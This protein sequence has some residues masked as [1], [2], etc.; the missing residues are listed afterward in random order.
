MLGIVNLAG[1]SRLQEAEFA[2][3]FPI[4]EENSQLL[5]QLEV[6]DLL[7]L[8]LA[9]SSLIF[10]GLASLIGSALDVDGLSASRSWPRSQKPMGALRQ[11]QQGLCPIFN[12][13]DIRRSSDGAL[14]RSIHSSSIPTLLR[15]LSTPRRFP[16]PPPRSRSGRT[17]QLL[18]VLSLY[19]ING[20]R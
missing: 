10:A 12:D 15:R 17:A 20:D 13:D 18:E 19:G 14:S 11:D 4:R 9:S 6:K 3:L 7:L 1:G 5:K 2:S 8:G 16:S